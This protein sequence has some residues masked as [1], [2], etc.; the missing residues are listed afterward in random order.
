MRSLAIGY[1]GHMTVKLFE[2]RRREASRLADEMI[3]LIELIGDP[4]LTAALSLA[5]STVKC[6][7][8]EM[9]EVLRLT[10]RV[11]SLAGDGTSE[12]ARF[13]GPRSH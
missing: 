10:Q 9:A 5:P 7:T 12:D 6:E 13:I 1:N 8:R 3:S 2:G 11:I 4:A